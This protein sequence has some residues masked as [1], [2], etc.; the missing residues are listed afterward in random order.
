MPYARQ[1]RR[2]SGGVLLGHELTLLHAS[3]VRDGFLVFSTLNSIASIGR[4]SRFA[5]MRR[6]AS[7]ASVCQHQSPCKR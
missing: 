7:A 5:E 1:R 4:A 3:E 6:L 2:R